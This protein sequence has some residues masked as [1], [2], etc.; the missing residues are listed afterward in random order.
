L[1][2]RCINTPS[3]YLHEIGGIET[4][5]HLCLSVE[6]T[7]VISAFIGQLKGGS[8]HD[9]N[10]K[11]GHKVL[12]WQAGY[13]VVSFGTRDLAWV[14]AYVAN[15]RERHGTGKTVD[16]LERINPAEAATAEA[17][18]REAL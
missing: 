11:L 8:S 7:I 9:V 2:G 3:V 4:H 14:K 5:V 18:H 12:E 10:Q 17:E 15:Q 16:R 1:R 6:P 13:G